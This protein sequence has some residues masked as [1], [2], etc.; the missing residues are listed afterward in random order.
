[1]KN[2]VECQKLEGGQQCLVEGITTIK[3]LRLFPNEIVHRRESFNA[4]KRPTD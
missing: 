4:S 1:M 2:I 3:C